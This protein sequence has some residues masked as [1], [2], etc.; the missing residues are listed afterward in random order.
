M[1]KEL[2]ELKEY[3]LKINN[4]VCDG[5]REG[6]NPLIGSWA[7][8]LF[9]SNQSTDSL[10]SAIESLEAKEEASAKGE[11]AMP[12]EMPYKFK[13][14]LARS[15]FHASNEHYNLLYRHVRQALTNQPKGEE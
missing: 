14:V 5:A 9:E 15:G 3:V 6:F 12:E 13:H 1:N 10:L 4:L 11:V 8:E 2:N 7:E